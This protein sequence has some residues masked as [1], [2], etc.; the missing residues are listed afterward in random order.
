MPQ[1]KYYCDYCDRSFVDSK[2]Q[3]EMHFKS[4][5]HQNNV[6]LWYQSRKG[7]YVLLISYIE[8]ATIVKEQSAIPICDVFKKTGF[9]P[10]GNQC[11][12]RHISVTNLERDGGSV[13]PCKLFLYNTTL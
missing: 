11:P 10:M 4:V 5:S 12:Y 7:Y 1:R 9:C 13:I 3:R 8:T 2:E 6:R